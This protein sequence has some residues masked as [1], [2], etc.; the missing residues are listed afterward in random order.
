MGNRQVNPLAFRVCESN[1]DI[2]YM[3]TVEVDK[4]SFREIMG[5]IESIKN[6][7]LTTYMTH[8]NVGVRYLLEVDASYSYDNMRVYLFNHKQS[9]ILR[10][11]VN[12]SGGVNSSTNNCIYR[13]CYMDTIFGVNSQPIQNNH[14]KLHG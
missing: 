1:E 8:I 4:P 11:F 9:P 6:E 7:V 12:G 5:K 13:K 14:S 2:D 10:I 3:Y